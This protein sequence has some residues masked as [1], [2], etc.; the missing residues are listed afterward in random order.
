[1]ILVTGGTGLVGAHLLLHL[2]DHGEKVRAIYR[3][4]A[5]IDK[6]KS[7]F[8]LYKKELL[9]D[10]I[11]WIQADITE[12]PS[13]EIAFQ[14]IDTVYHCAALISFDPKDEN[15]LRK[16]NIEGTA[17]IVS[18][19]IAYQI[20][21]LCFISSIATLGDLL[22]H[23]KFITEETEWNPEK[24][25]TDY[26]ISKYGAEMEI[27]RGQQEG[28][29]V[30]IVNPGVILGPGFRAQGSGQLFTKVKNGL[31]FYTLGSTGF[32][33]VT[34]VVR[35]A[36]QLMQSEI[37]NERFTLI[38]E[39]NIFRDILN[40]MADTL[41]VRRPTIHAKPL[42]MKILWRLDWCVS[43]IFQQKRKLSHA[44]AKAS[45]SKNRYSNEKIKNRLKTDFTN[46]TDYIKYI[47][48]H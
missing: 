27:W 41:G 4:I 14:N 23:E 7:L 29:D 35:I 45:Y 15:L 48:A 6:T 46:I 18:F 42:F 12:I 2:I 25:H 43:T 8:S 32:V 22:P 39:N 11:E 13:L 26:A 34:D 38:A 5:S 1:M 10:Q 17:N 16:T 3:S 20:K 21:K 9:Y 47:S 44:T 28:L 31:K 37:K 24:Y 40:T 30:I 36:H 19:C 33:A